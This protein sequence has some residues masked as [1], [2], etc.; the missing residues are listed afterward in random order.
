[1]DFGL[2]LK[3]F[4]RFN[5]IICCANGNFFALEID[6]YSLLKATG[7]KIEN[8]LKELAEQ[9]GLRIR[10]LLVLPSYSSLRAVFTSEIGDRHHYPNLEFRCPTQ[11]RGILSVPYP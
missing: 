9:T 11:E 2:Y 6:S 3:N 7:A 1:M 5:V 8:R 4:L 10:Y